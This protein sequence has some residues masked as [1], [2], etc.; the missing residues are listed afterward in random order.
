MGGTPMI[1]AALMS[2]D[3]GDPRSVLWGFAAVGALVLACIGVLVATF[4][5]M[6]FPSIAWGFLAV[7][8]FGLICVSAVCSVVLVRDLLRRGPLTDSEP[9]SSGGRF[10]VP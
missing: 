9:L 3:T 8:L 2:R 1:G 10:R 5:F 4:L 6:A 7:G